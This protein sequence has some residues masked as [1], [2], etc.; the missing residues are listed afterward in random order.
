MTLRLTNWPLPE[1][2]LLKEAPTPMRGPVAE[3]SP[4][5]RS[6]LSGSAGCHSVLSNGS[7]APSAG[8]GVLL[9][10]EKHASLIVVASPPL[11]LPLL[12]VRKAALMPLTLARKLIAA[13]K[14]PECVALRQIFSETG[15]QLS[16]YAW[17][18]GYAYSQYI[19]GL[20]TSMARGGASP[21]FVSPRLS[22]HRGGG[23]EG[24][25]NAGGGGVGGGTGDG[26][27]GGGAGGVDGGGALGGA[28]GVAGGGGGA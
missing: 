25:G 5:A 28:G 6:G 16:G 21:P 9:S 2:E 7:R 26:S 3:P 12:G 14:V 18:S 22:A 1:A 19:G 27:S 23:G 24:C 17:R 11:L 15:T 8:N 10:S 13:P 20:G 4:L